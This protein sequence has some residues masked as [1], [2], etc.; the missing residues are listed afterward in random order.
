MQCPG[1]QKPFTT[2]SVLSGGVGGGAEDDVWMQLNVPQE[3]RFRVRCPHCESILYAKTSMVGR[4]MRCSDCHSDVRIPRPPRKTKNAP[5]VATATTRS[6][7][8]VEQEFMSASGQNVRAEGFLEIAE[9]DARE[10]DSVQAKVS[11][12]TRSWTR[13][14]F[15]IFRDPGV[16]S[17]LIALAVFLSVP[18]AITVWNTRYGFATFPFMAIGFSLVMTCGLAIIQ[19]V[20][21]G[22]ET[23]EDWPTIDLYAWLESSLVVGAALICAITPSLFLATLFFADTLVTI[24]LMLIGAHLVFPFVVLSMLDSQSVLVPVSL[25]VI[26][27]YK[28]SGLECRRFYS[29]AGA[30]LALPILYF[31]FAP[32]TPLAAGIGTAAC[33][34]VA[35]LYA[36]MLGRLAFSLGESA[37]SM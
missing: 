30:V 6:S 26:K 13:M 22:H 5:S 34:L 18:V 3:R 12:R 19:S 11:Q 36:A 35:F 23:V 20:G 32:P 16:I 27:S 2:P 37:S 33:V 21:N 14:V 24:G 28:R 1:C 15:G 17:H 8:D 7:E 29:A 25:D 10:A 9:N 4:S 31:G